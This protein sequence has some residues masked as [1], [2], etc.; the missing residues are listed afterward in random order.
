MTELEYREAKSTNRPMLL[1]V[2]KDSAN[3]KIS[4]FE[5]SSIGREKL[6]ELKDEILKEKMV[7]KFETIAELEKQVYADLE[8]IYI[9]GR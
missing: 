6:K 5:Q 1:Y 9:L 7:F 4:D 3:V 8:K 2:L